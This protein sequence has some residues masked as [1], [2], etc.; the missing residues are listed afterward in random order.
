MT[1]EQIIKICD[2]I[3]GYYQLPANIQR[4]IDIDRLTKG[5]HY[6]NIDPDF[7]EEMHDLVKEYL[8]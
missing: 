6:K 5:L 1:T 7:I 3:K 8:D 2:T 4:R